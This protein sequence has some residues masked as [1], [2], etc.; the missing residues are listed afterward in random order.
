MKKL[1]RI[2]DGKLDTSTIL[3]EHYMCEGAK[4]ETYECRGSDG[5]K[6][7]CSKEN[8]GFLTIEEA[9]RDELN[10]A[11]D[12]VSN[13][14]QQIQDAFE[15]SQRASVYQQQIQKEYEKCTKQNESVESRTE[16]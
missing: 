10:N 7:V 9:W 8:W 6:F 13:S 3:N 4:A 2:I 5:R 15:S 11:N 1:Y 14:Q 12:W 16:R